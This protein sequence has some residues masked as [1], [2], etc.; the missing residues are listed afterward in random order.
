MNRDVLAAMSSAVE[1]AFKHYG[2]LFSAAIQHETSGQTVKE[3]NTHLISKILD[4]LEPFLDPEILV[5][6]K[7]EMERLPLHGDGNLDAN[8]GELVL[9]KL[10]VTVGT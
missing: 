9:R 7:A 8:A 6:P 3:A 4:V 2:H 10:S 1:D 5:I